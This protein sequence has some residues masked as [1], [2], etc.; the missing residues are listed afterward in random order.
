[1]SKVW[2][3][4]SHESPTH[5]T[6]DGSVASAPRRLLRGDGLGPPSVSVAQS[7][8][9]AG[10][11]IALTAGVGALLH[12]YGYNVATFDAPLTVLVLAHAT[13]L[14]QDFVATEPSVVVLGPGVG[15]P[16]WP[17][18]PM[19]H[20]S[21]AIDINMVD[22]LLVPALQASVRGATVISRR[23]LPSGVS[24]LTAEEIEWMRELRRGRKAIDLAFAIGM[25]E[26]TFYRRLDQVY[27][28]LG[29]SGRREALA[30]LGDD[31]APQQA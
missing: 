4:P 19:T 23:L 17:H 20:T 12:G 16:F 14:W 3:S 30:V 18:S 29:V 10:D 6:F 11:S 24:A 22:A 26:R 13:S 25:S 5:Q 31:A 7:V 8:S 27:K 15:W 2:H 9:I 1:M 28:K 21:C